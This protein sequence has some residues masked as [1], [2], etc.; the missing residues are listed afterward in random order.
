MNDEHPAR[1]ASTRSMA[2]VEAGDRETWLGLFADDA[3]IEDPI[4]PSPLDPEG[5]GHHGREAIAAFFDTMIAPSQVRFDITSSYA[6]GN[7]VA[8]VGTIT[9]TLA[10]GSRVIVEGVFCYQVGDDGLIRSLR[11]FWEFESARIEA[12]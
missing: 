11:A 10:D 7:E 9:T 6:A 5:R 8:N 1:E 3:V 2:A 4:G 12:P